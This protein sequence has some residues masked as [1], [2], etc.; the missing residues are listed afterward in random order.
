MMLISV[1]GSGIILAREEWPSP[2]VAIQHHNQ[3]LL[4]EYCTCSPAKTLQNPGTKQEFPRVYSLCSS[5]AP[6]FAG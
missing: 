3:E 6:A 1:Q 4:I 5:C 2:C